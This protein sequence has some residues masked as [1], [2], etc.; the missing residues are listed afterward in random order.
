[1][2]IAA[3]NHVQL[4]FPAGAEDAIRHFYSGLLGLSELRW[5]PGSTLRFAA[6]PQRIDLVPTEHWQPV[7]A[8]P[9]LALEVQDLPSL[10]HRLLQA[11]VALDETRALPGYR[12]FYA[13]D[14]AGNQLEFIEPDHEQETAP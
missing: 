7:S 13:N 3:I 4:S 11:E 12:R 1:M 10:R 5:Q 9:H 2:G 8:V 14:P 6:G